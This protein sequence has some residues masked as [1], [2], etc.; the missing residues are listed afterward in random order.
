MQEP[1]YTS[2]VGVKER[3]AACAR[4]DDTSTPPANIA[5]L[6]QS[7]PLGVGASST[8]VPCAVAT[9]SV[10]DSRGNHNRDDSL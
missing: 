6:T 2:K 8:P 9:F 7:P 4:Y 3:S 10:P 5:S 1:A